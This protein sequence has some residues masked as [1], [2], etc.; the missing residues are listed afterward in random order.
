MNHLKSFIM[1]VILI[2]IFVFDIYVKTI[3]I[4]SFNYFHSMIYHNKAN[5]KDIPGMV[6]FMNAI[7]SEINKDGKE[8]VVLVSGGDNYQVTIVSYDTKGATVN[9]IFK[10][11]RCSG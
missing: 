3:C 11:L 4:L 5:Y 8:N 6:F 1:I 7:Q 2:F 9:D 10:G